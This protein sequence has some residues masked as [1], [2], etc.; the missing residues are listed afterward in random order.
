[1]PIS[2]RTE[3]AA[4]VQNETFCTSNLAMVGMSKLIETLRR[5]HWVIAGQ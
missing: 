3:D 1:M 2:V 4:S 5:S